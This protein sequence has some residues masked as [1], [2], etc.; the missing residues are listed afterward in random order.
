MSNL[1]DALRRI[2]ENLDVTTVLREVINS[3]R[4]LTGARY[5]MIITV[6]A[7]GQP[8]DIVASG[9]TNDEEQRLTSCLPDGPML[10]EYLRKQ[11]RPLRLDDFPGHVQ[12]LGLSPELGVCQTLQCT[13]MRHR[14]V[15]VGTFF[16]GDKEGGEVFTGEDEELLVLLA[17]QAAAAFVNARAHNDERRARAG[18]EALVEASPV[19]VVVFDAG[20]RMPAIVNR[21]ARRIVEVLGGP[22]CSAMDLLGEFTSQ[23]SDGRKVTVDDLMTAKTVRDIEVELS[24]PEGR[25]I[26]MLV[27]TAP[28]HSDTDNFEAVLVIMQ[29]L[30]PLVEFERMRVEFLAMVSHELRTPHTPIKGSTTSLLTTFNRAEIRQFIRIIDQGGQPHGGSRPRSARCWAHPRGHTLRRPRGSGGGNPSGASEDDVHERRTPTDSA[31]RPA[32]G[33]SEGVGRRTAHCASAEQPV[34]KCGTALASIITHR[35]RRR[36]RWH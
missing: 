19:G 13:P 23:L 20:T 27:N 22:G 18:L 5:G 15:H 12:S 2:G 17:S 4:A 35:C 29:D 28:I 10:F 24:V 8:K 32:A 33:S 34:V 14:D 9:L 7:S 3:A 36:A 21:E 26:R 16:V 25:S 11:Q 1:I 30:A 31:H 6:D